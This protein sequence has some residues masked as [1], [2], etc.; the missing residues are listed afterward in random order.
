MGRSFSS[1][2][3]RFGDLPPDFSSRAAGPSSTHAS[4]IAADDDDDA[5]DGDGEGDAVDPDGGRTSASGP[6]SPSSATTLK[7]SSLLAFPR[8]IDGGARASAPLGPT[9]KARSCVR[10]WADSEA[11]PSFSAPRRED[12]LHSA[13]EAFKKSHQDL[14]KFASS[15]ADFVGAA[16]HAIIHASDV[17]R[18]FLDLLVES[19]NDPQ[20]GPYFAKVREDAKS[21]IFA[22]LDDAASCCAAVYGG[23]VSQIRKGVTA[24]ADDAVKSVLKS[25]PPAGGYF[26]GDP[27]DA[28]H[29]QLSYAFMSSSLK[30][31]A[32]AR[33]RGSHASY[34]A[35][36]SRQPAKPASSSSASASSSA[37]PAGNAS[38]RSSRGGRGG[39]RKK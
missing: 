10:R 11:A 31:K 6:K 29:A 5:D 35:R 13:F 8:V 37:K 15:S 7:W 30:A 24:A 4:S 32:P 20:W 17:I 18:G 16:A 34:A 26:F 28:L 21:T 36:P 39:Q 25:K 3:N 12:C 33:S 23:A 22:P 38:G 27:A 9:S 2:T 1:G 14:F 19:I